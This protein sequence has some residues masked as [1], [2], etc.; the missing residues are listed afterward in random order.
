MW[1][2]FFETLY[3]LS[4][5]IPMPRARNW[6]RREKLFDYG[7]KRDALRAACPELNRVITARVNKQHCLGFIFD[8]Q[9][10]YKVR[11]YYERDNSVEKFEYEKRITDAIA[12]VLPIRVPH[13][14]LIQTNPYLFYKTTFIPGRVLVDLPLT[15]IR[16]HREKIGRQLGNV[17]Y[18]LFNTDFPQLADLQAERATQWNLPADD[19]G[20]THGDMCSNIIVNPDTMDGVGIIDWEYAGYTS[21]KNEFIGMFRVRRKMR[22]TDIGPLAMWQYYSLQ[23]EHNKKH[24]PKK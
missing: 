19:I 17:I 18:T 3:F 14:E 13:V 23:R 22:Q 4:Y 11:K 9:C 8:N 1:K 6:F 5:L 7:K 16:E 10:V 12:P 20:L 15:R 24:K 21:L 2:T